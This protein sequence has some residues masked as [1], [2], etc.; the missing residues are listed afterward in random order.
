VINFSS[1][2]A[3]EKEKLTMNK[4][5]IALVAIA[6]ALSVVPPTIYAEEYFVI[7]N[8]MGQTAVTSGL[9]GYG[10]SIEQGPFATVDAAQR[11]TGTG[12]G[13][14]LDNVF[15]NGRQV[16]FPSQTIPR[17]SMGAFADTTP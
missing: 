6:V 4:L 2:I 1:R 10:W 13:N 7:R 12:V 3:R 14:Q 17:G 15:L 8:Q 5:G 11:A 16:D 9:P